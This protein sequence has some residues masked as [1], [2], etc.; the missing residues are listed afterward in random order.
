MKQKQWK[1]GQQVP[2]F[3]YRTA[4]AENL[5][6]YDALTDKTI[7][8]VHRYIGCPIC[9]YDIKELADQYSKITAKGGQVIVVMQSDPEHVRADLESTDTTLPFDI[10][11]DTE[12]E[13]YNTLSVKPAANMLTLAGTGVVGFVGKFAKATLS[14]I[15]HGDY[16]GNEQQLP[17]LFVL[18]KKGTITYAHYAKNIADMPDVDG[19]A[20]LL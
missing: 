1:A 8:L 4:Y 19:M 6:L 11:C 3:K 7:L 13:I 10:I 16:E 12:Q 20:A 18:D 14:G 15:K 5:D 9:R 17:A 2:N